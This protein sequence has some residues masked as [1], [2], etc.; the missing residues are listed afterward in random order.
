MPLNHVPGRAVHHPKR[1]SQ[2][3]GPGLGS[4]SLS[5]VRSRI[6]TIARCCQR[7]APGLRGGVVSG[8]ASAQ[9]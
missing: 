4:T 3:C 1:A 7:R 6:H 9:S 2:A 5:A 8:G